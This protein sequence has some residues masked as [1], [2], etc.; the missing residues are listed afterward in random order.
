MGLHREGQCVFIIPIKSGE[1][2]SHHL[3]LGLPRIRQVD[4]VSGYPALWFILQAN[5]VGQ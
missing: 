2:V 3:R 1:K 4:I 5:R